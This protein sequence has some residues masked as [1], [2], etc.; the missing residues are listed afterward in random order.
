VATQEPQRSSGGLGHEFRS[1]L[2]LIKGYAQ[3]VVRLL[4]REN[5]PRERILTHA[6]RVDSELVTLER[7]SDDLLQR[8]EQ[9]RAVDTPGDPRNAER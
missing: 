3:L 6:E 4:R 9:R 7:L 1:Q 8:S 2:T 5:V